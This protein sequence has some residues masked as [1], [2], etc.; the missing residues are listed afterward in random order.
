MQFMKI[1]VTGGA[2]FI[3]S[4]TIVEL[5]SAGMEPVIVDNFSNS[6]PEVL[7]CLAQITGRQIESHNVDVT[8]EAALREV[9][10]LVRPDGVIHFAAYKAVGE[11]VKH[12]LDYYRNN[13]DSTMTLSVL[14]AEFGV[15]NLVFSSSATVYGGAT[16]MPISEDAHVTATNPYGQTKLMGEQILKDVAISDP[17]M[18][19][20][21]LRYFNPVGAHESGL[22][23]EEP[24]GTPNNIM[25][26]IAEVATARRPRLSVYG[27]DYPTPDG[28]GV[29]D[30][31]HVVDLALAHVNALKAQQN[32]RGLKIYN[33]GAGK[34]YSVLELIRSFEKVS[35]RKIPYDVVGRRPGDVATCY[36]DPSLAEKELGWKATKTLTQMCADVWRF[37]L[38]N[39]TGYAKASRN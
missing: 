24:K 26:L 25:P 1:L 6:S 13:L 16:Q 27:D 9:F 21:L 4:H 23:G 31:I 12:P 20:T 39:P 38:Q 10:K 8:N 7:D 22:I 11:S 29:R 37:Q 17:S 33:I 3:G 18:H 32:S 34:G 14:M 19:I 36:A 15:K 30:Y 5:V 35:E 2:G 28:T